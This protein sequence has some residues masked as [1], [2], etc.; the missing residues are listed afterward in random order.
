M[1]E[2]FKHPQGPS[3]SSSS[4]GDDNKLLKGSAIWAS[5]LVLLFEISKVVFGSWLYA[6]KQQVNDKI[7]TKT[8]EK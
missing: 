8:K 4:G 2:L 7:N 6:V 5:Y 3:S 1:L